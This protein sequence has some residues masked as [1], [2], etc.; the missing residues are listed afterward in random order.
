MSTLENATTDVVMNISTSAQ[1]A[2]VMPKG[3]DPKNTHSNSHPNTIEFLPY[4][5]GHYIAAAA[6]LTGLFLKVMELWP[7]TI[8][9]KMNATSVS[10]SNEHHLSLLMEKS[11]ENNSFDV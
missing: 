5:D 3:F 1:M 10:K 7:K 6:A 4:L 8:L 2:F 9:D 11:F